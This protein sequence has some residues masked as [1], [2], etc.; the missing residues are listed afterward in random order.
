MASIS[1]LSVSG[2]AAGEQRLIA[3]ASVI[4]RLSTAVK[5]VVALAGRALQAG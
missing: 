4:H 1:G 5:T 3:A 2:I